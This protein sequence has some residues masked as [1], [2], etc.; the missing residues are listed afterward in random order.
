MTN[1]VVKTYNLR[2]YAERISQAKARIDK[3][4]KRLNTLYKK[5]GL[6]GLLDLLDAGALTYYGQRLEECQS[7]LEETAND[8]ET[9]EKELS[10][11]DPTDFNLPLNWATMDF[12]GGQLGE[13]DTFA[14]KFKSLLEAVI[15]QASEEGDANGG[16]T[17][18]EKTSDEG[19]S[20]DGKET[21][22]FFKFMAKVSGWYSKF[23][24]D[25]EK[26][27]S[28]DFAFLSSAL[29]YF[30]GLYTFSTA[31]YNSAEDVIQNGLKLT[32][33]STSAWSGVYKYLEND[34]NNRFHARVTAQFGKKYQKTVGYVSLVGSLC[35]FSGDAIDTLKTL[36]DKESGICEKV[37]SV[38]KNTS[39]G[40]DVAKSVINLK[41]GQ[42]VL[43][44][45]IHAKYQWGVAAKNVK[46]LEKTNTCLS[47]FEVGA[48]TLTSGINAYKETSADGFVDTHDMAEIAI[49]GSVSGLISIIGQGT[50]GLTNLIGL[51]ECSEEISE[52]IINFADTTMTDYVLAH[53]YSS[54]YVEN[55]SF[56][57]D[58][59]NDPEKNGFCRVCAA[60]AAG[61]GMLGA[62]VIDGVGDC[63]SWIGEKT[64][65]GWSWISEKAGA[66]WNSIKNKF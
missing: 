40:S 64:S 55:A 6:Q 46:A 58:Y 44:R 53:E 61:T 23:I 37:V 18:V 35:G 29:S 30:A 62:I 16:A 12:G 66:G 56:L 59:A 2:N 8:F 49:K 22:D 17:I 41:Y 51:P 20:N 3:L 38:L 31:D 65:A 43:T 10:G 39:S 60:T 24:K 34:L 25:K 9:V 28:N 5:V 11:C 36:L 47:L 13:D 14:E 42:K 45:D 52:G 32:K 15:A 57:M 48:D 1:I 21:S 27:K 26:D 33:T 19:A 63:T 4:D 50:F 54:Q 7:Y